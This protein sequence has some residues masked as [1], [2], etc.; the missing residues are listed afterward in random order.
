LALAPVVYSQ[1][2]FPDGRALIAESGNAL[3]AAR[4]YQIEQS[5]VVELSGGIEHRLQ[6][7]VKLAASNPDKL[8]IESDGAVGST[9]VI[10]DGENTWM[11]LGPVKQYTKTPAASS[12]EA[13]LKSL[14]PGVADILGEMKTKDP[15]LSVRV[16]GEE[17]IETGGQRYE[18][19]VVESKL[20]RIKMP[21]T[22]TLEDGVIKMWI[23][24]K[25][26]L[27][28]KQTATAVMQGGA[29]RMPAQ[30]NQTITMLSVKLNQQLPDA[31]FVFTPPAGAQEVK[32][33]EGLVRANADLSGK[34]APDFKLNSL[35][36]KEF[37]LQALRGKVVLLD[38]WATWCLPCRRDIP[39]LEKIYADF[40]ERGLVM[41][42]MN[43][44]ENKETVAKFLAQNKLSYPIVLA[45]ENEML[46]SYSVTAFPTVVLIDREGVI[47]LY[48]VGSGG[49][50]ELRDALAKLGF[51]K[52][53]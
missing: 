13:L 37:S 12:P 22:L 8:R 23:D 38:F 40:H 3:R 30:M 17:T 53:E 46:Q 51:S 20:D 41:I 14:N 26:K 31:L 28:L 15:F 50:T 39:S 10:S 34:D 18:C 2:P 16:T 47:Y 35:D 21:G 4:T 19:F 6:L 52:S 43:V 36:G 9:L 48:H 25:T 33:F 42:G 32:E 11:Y 1:T 7:P 29:L 27:S 45:G 44:G 5:V 49:E 24:K